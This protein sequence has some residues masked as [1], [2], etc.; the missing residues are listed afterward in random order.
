M[1]KKRR[2]RK[3]FPTLSLG[4]FCQNCQNGINPEDLGY[5]VSDVTRCYLKLNLTFSLN[6]AF[7][8]DFLATTRTELRRLLFTAVSAQPGTRLARKCPLSFC[9]GETMRGQHFGIFAPE[10]HYF[11]SLFLRVS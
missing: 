7:A 5:L 4:H 10:L 9:Q 8:N 2:K 3:T 11:C 6:I 1:D